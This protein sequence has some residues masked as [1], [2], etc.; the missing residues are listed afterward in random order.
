M[1]TCDDHEQVL[2]SDMR[3]AGTK[4]RLF[5]VI[6]P[7]IGCPRHRSPE[8]SYEAAFNELPAFERAL[9][10]CATAAVTLIIAPPM[11]LYYGVKWVF[12]WRPKSED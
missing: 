7:P 6:G 8:D 10:N 3:R 2:T 12:G 9:I 11:L 5:P 4:Y 1:L